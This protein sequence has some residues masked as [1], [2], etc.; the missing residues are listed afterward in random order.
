MASWPGSTVDNRAKLNVL[1]SRLIG[2]LREAF[3][4]LT[5]EPDLRAAVLTGAGGRAFIGGADIAEM[6]TLSPATART[7]IT[8][9]TR[10]LRNH[11]DAAGSGDRAHRRLLPG[12]RAGS[13]RRL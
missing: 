8:G 9:I 5:S 2:D 13:G 12:R 6:V 4:G 3:E 10:A 7:F 11:P 1:G